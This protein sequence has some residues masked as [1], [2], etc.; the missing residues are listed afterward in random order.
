[1][2]KLGFVLILIAVL[3]SGCGEAATITSNSVN[4]DQPEITK[5]EVTVPVVESVVRLK[6]TKEEDAPVFDWSKAEVNEK[7]VR[8]A[9]KDT[10]HAAVSIMLTDT[11]FRK[12]VY[13][14]D[15]KGKYID[16]TVNPGMFGDV[17]DF[18]RKSGGSLLAYSKILFENPEVYE[19]S[20]STKMDNVGGGE[21]DGVYI[22]W[23]REQTEGIDYDKALDNMF[24]DYTIPYALARKYYIPR[25]IYE[26]LPEPS[27][28]MEN[29]L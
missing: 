17:K 9:L 1:M 22:S 24:G 13:S 29:N 28:P 18:V 2:R 12:F 26:R 19:V 21:N 6:E 15:D 7:N 27:I 11:T 23:R 4:K 8:E 20:I 10:G 14:E 25:D 5:E 16:I 3:A